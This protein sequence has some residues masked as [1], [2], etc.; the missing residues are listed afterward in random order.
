VFHVGLK[1]IVAKA[2]IFARVKKT[3]NGVFLPQPS[4]TTGLM[5]PTSSIGIAI[6]F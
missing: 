4:V 5:A 2:F 6:T 3:G 1:L